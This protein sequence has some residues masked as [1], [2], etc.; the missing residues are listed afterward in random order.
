MPSTDGPEKSQ[1]R[2]AVSL[3]SSGNARLIHE[4]LS[5]RGFATGDIAI[6]EAG[7]P[8]FDL[9]IVDAAAVA[10][11]RE[12]LQ[13]CRSIMEPIIL[14]VLVLVEGRGNGAGRI[15]REL[16]V[17][18]DDIIRIP[19]TREELV[20]RIDNLLRLRSLSRDLHARYEQV[21]LALRGANRALWIL[22]TVNEVLVRA[23][24]EQ[25]L[26]H[27]ICR[28]VIEAENYKLA[29]AGFVHDGDDPEILLDAVAGEKA[30]CTEALRL[31][32]SQFAGAP[33]WRA[34]ETGKAIV[35]KDILREPALQDM[36]GTLQSWGLTSEI[37][38]PLL[39][40]SGSHGVLV[41]YAGTRGE[42]R[43]DERDVLERLATNI[44]FGLNALRIGEERNKQK[45][46][47]HKLAYTDALTGLHNRHSVTERLDALLSGAGPKKK[48]ATLFLDLDR[49]KIINDALGHGVGDRVLRQVAQRLHQVVR[50]DDLV[51]RQ[52]G[53]EFIVVMAE[54]PRSNE[55]QESMLGADG[56]EAAAQALAER[57][58]I[59]VRDPLIIEGEK[60]H[61]GV[62][63]GISLYPEHG[64]NA[65]ELINCAD[66]AM[67]T[68]KK[69]GGHVYTYSN[70]IPQ[71]QHRRLSLEARL[72]NALDADE[73]RLHYQP[74]FDMVSG[75]I[76]GVE[77]L[78]RWPQQD[79]GQLS[80]ADF[81]PAA[82]ETG[83]I[84]PLG[85]WVLRT[86]IAQQAAWLN[87]GHDLMMSVNVSVLQF[88]EES[89]IHRLL[90]ALDGAIDPTRIELEVTESD[91]MDGK[92]WVESTIET[93]HTRG[94]RIAIDDFG[95]GYSSLSRLQGMPIDTLKIDKSFVAE[96]EADGRGAA[97]TSTIQRLAEN[98]GFHTIAEGVETNKQRRSLIEMGCSTGQGFLVSAALPSDQL[99]TMLDH[100]FSDDL[101]AD[102]H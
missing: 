84:V 94:F 9:A 45:E 80:P 41:I 70:L 19:S 1:P 76:E 24:D 65:E 102:Q 46:A 8:E 7:Q 2:I 17:T 37:A 31:P 93:L 71:Q 34:V 67:Y 26:L 18:V 99:V 83:L 55:W 27:D 89:S 30:G 23:R 57:L 11:S 77:A 15:T 20:A 49:F 38:I 61:L 5:D 12:F 98:L 88:Q 79:G 36:R 60:H 97:I 68:A 87:D 14:P 56:L 33:A 43:E 58:A 6:D 85:E 51:A 90:V 91:L 50:P 52:G 62:S 29:W 28:V 63:I 25:E 13:R 4:I 100:H 81:I 47:A 40:D 35:V 10:R 64:T 44:E 3:Q 39:P 96:L 59:C 22:H 82:E 48:F 86:A 21:N 73:F 69:T 78:I 42:F 75:T 53:D 101:D 95:T 74:L 72:R 32:R 66:S 54:P 16:T 92:D